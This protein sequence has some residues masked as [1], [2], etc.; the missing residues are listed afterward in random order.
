MNMKILNYWKSFGTKITA[1]RFLSHKV[2]QVF[3]DAY[4]DAVTEYVET[5]YSSD[6][7]QNYTFSQSSNDCT[8]SRIIWSMWWQ[9]TDNMPDII[10][11]CTRSIRENLPDGFEYIVL[12]RNNISDYF[13]F[14]SNLKQKI[15]SGA[16]SLTHLSDIIRFSVLSRFGGLWLDA[17]MFTARTIDDQ[18][19]RM[20]F[21]T[22][23]M[24]A[25]KIGSVSSGRWMLPCWY[26][27][28]NEQ[29]P[30]C[31]SDILTTYWDKEECQIDY[32]LTDYV[33]NT[34]YLGSSSVRTQIDEM[35]QD[36]THI[37]DLDCEMNKPYDKVRYD[38]II[39]SSQ[40]HKINWKK[41]Y[42]EEVDG[43]TTMYGHWISQ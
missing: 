31:I 37:F 13:D 1:L 23:R 22:A 8:P 25:I 9:G 4:D 43:K 20:N 18:F 32:F 19:L 24:P 35:P 27:A 17:T 3:K 10:Q 42:A 5:K 12:D 2:S 40:F 21:Y 26:S 15:E 29:I 30:K 28:K 39:D 14:S 34:L 16:V 33:V 38:E 36:G 41:I 11:K 7:R 6:V